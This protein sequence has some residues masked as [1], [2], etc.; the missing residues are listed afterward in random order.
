MK[1]WKF[2]CCP[3]T[4]RNS[5]LLTYRGT[6]HSRAF[7]VL[8]LVPLYVYRGEFLK[9]NGQQP[10]FQDDFVNI[11]YHLSEIS[12][13][14]IV[15]KICWSIWTLYNYNYSVILLTIFTADQRIHTQNS[16]KVTIENLQDTNN[17]AC[18]LYSKDFKFLVGI[19]LYTMA[20]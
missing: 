6:N 8:W 16:C 1:S 3:L 10:N 19:L 7:D 14:I 5:P 15:C 12:C 13:Q 11:H 17:L 18:L 9:V 2:G 20:L 4:L